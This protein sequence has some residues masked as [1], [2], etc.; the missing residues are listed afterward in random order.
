MDLGRELQWFPDPH[1]YEP[2]ALLVEDTEVPEGPGPKASCC[3]DSSSRR[4]LWPRDG[5]GAA[6]PHS[7]MPSATR[8]CL[9]LLACLDTP[10]RAPWP[11]SPRPEAFT[12]SPQQVRP[13]AQ[14]VCLPPR[15]SGTQA[16]PRPHPTPHFWFPVSP[17]TLPALSLYSGGKDHIQV[18]MPAKAWPL[19]VSSCLASSP[20]QFCPRA[21]SVTLGMSNMAPPATCNP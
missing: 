13:H 11:L 3:P 19:P 15:V 9:V 10:C 4:Q 2:M 1:Q 14:G 17:P 12:L 6:R 21:L 20:H 8:P 16:C 18:Q 5:T 7:K